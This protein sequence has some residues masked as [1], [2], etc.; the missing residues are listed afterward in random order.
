MRDWF[1]TGI[2]LSLAGM[3]GCGR[4]DVIQ[5]REM[6]WPALDGQVLSISTFNGDIVIRVAGEDSIR[7]VATVS[8]AL[9][10]TDAESVE[11]TFAPGLASSLIARRPDQLSDAG[12]SFEVTIP[13]RVS[14]GNLET[15]NGTVDVTGAGGSPSIDTSNGDVTLSSFSGTLVIDTSNGDVTV[16]G[17]SLTVGSIDTSNGDIEVTASAF[18]PGAVLDTSNGDI[19]VR[20]TAECSASFRMDTS[21]GGI[22]LMGAGFHG[23]EVDG[24][25][26]TASFGE[27]GPLVSVT[28]SN[29]SI[30]LIA[31]E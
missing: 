7:A 20:L 8:T 1:R 5:V 21:N 28:S 13:G 3:L 16:D 6:S 17:Q 2:L 27:N 29:G 24:D 31:P 22:S 10:M 12:V 26:G 30:T 4:A 18:L 23:V 15:S 14:I 9:G 19:T 11:V 25:E